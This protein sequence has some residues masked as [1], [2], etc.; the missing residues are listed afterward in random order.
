MQSNEV[1]TKPVTSPRTHVRLNV[2]IAGVGGQGILTIAKAI[3]NAAISRGWNAK[4]SEVH[5]MSQ[6]GGSVYSHVRVSDQTIHSDLIPLGECDLIL[7]MEPLEALRYASY[8]SDTGCIIS[9]TLPLVNMANYPPIEG[10]LERISSE[11]R[12]VLIDASRWAREAGAVLAANAVL[13]G[14]A[15]SRLGFS[16]DELQEAIARQLQSKGARVVDANRKAFQ[17]G[18]LAASAYSEAIRSTQEPKTVR[19]W[20]ANVSSEA[21]LAGRAVKAHVDGV[22]Q[23][24]KLSAAEESGISQVLQKALLEGRSSLF[25]HEVYQIV[26]LAGA[27]S[28][29]RHRVIRP[30]ETV[31][32]ADID[33]FPGD[34][35]VLKIISRDI[36]HKSDV[37]GVVFVAKDADSVD[38]SLR[39]LVERR[40]KTGANV[41]G[42]LLVECIEHE[43]SG[44]GQELFV[45]IRF[46]REFGNVIAAGLGGVDT[47]YLAHK[48]KPGVAVAKALV[49]ETT[50]EDFF[51]LFKTTA[52]YDVLAGRIRGHHRVVSDDEL[53]RCFRAFLAIA[54]RFSGDTNAPSS[55]LELEV[56]PFAFSHEKMVPLDGRGRLGSITPLRLARP[57]KKIANLLEPRSIAVVGVSGK[58]ENFGRIILENI[59]DCGFSREHLY[60]IKDGT[61][62]INGVRCVSDVQHLP[63]EIDVLVISVSHGLAELFDGAIASGKVSSII[64]IPGGL[65]ETAGTE[66]LQDLLQ[67]KITSSR[68][69]PGAGLIVLG[70]NT[71][72]IRSRPGRYDTFFT[73]REKLDARRGEPTTRTALITQSG[74]FA[75]TRMS[76]LEAINPSL[77]ITIGNQIDLT[78]SDLFAAVGTRNDLDAIGVY[79]E[80]FCDGDGLEFVRALKSVVESGKT[81]VF[82][83][84]GRTAPGRSAT[85][86]HT[87]SIAGDYDVCQTSIAQAGAIVVD[88]FKEFEQVLEL[89]TL[90][91]AKKV[92][93]RRIGILSN[94]GFEVVGMADTIIGVRYA[95]EVAALSLA[96]QDRI[97][98]FL[99]PAKLDKLVNVRNPLDVTPMA[100]EAVYAA[101]A[102]AMI[103]DGGVDALVVSVVPFTSELKTTPEELQSGARSLVDELAAITASSEKPLAVV[104]DCG[105]PYEVLASKMRKAGVPVF[106]SCDQAIRSMGRYLCHRGKRASI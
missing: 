42:V 54:R 56:N 44:F 55:L 67:S 5:G 91:H 50:A 9:N 16:A 78:V 28:P 69:L 39:K 11:Q 81:V 12:N 53:I 62:E 10:V 104:I 64:L 72:G 61:T 106:P 71:L 43:E 40:A 37:G 7:S 75:I 30:A 23:D 6:R 60:V 59:L 86:G 48:M 95:L 66:T 19:E 101:C 80:G 88:T 90:F 47:E 25:E 13:L 103:E 46:S 24:A 63:E 36:T 31:R 92:H 18:R 84:A 2:I 57:R 33:S 8:L 65:G 102:K 26:E 29:P 35:V 32:Q 14:A 17:L 105:R 3:S 70:G 82:Y 21:L 94:A 83:K 27:I 74:G 77:A 22:D 4:E 98:E 34:R 76:N 41:E 58:R 15:S 99:A 49:H 85:A 87:A 97:R 20:M 96:S 93:G 68:E 45:G 79:M 100:N 51:E 89:A 38:E 73:P 1:I 52:A